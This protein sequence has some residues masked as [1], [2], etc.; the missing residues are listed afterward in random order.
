MNGN[1]NEKSKL[2]DPLILSSTLVGHCFP[3]N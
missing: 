2:G 3:V 1:A